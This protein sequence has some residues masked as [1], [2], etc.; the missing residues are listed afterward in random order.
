LPPAPLF[1]ESIAVESND[2]AAV[3][4]P[5]VMEVNNSPPPRLLQIAVSSRKRTTIHPSTSCCKL[6][7]TPPQQQ[8]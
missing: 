3:D 4:L 6:N 8:Q 1:I 7:V 2:D 5:A